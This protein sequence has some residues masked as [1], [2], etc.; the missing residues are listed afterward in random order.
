MFIVSENPVY[1][2]IHKRKRGNKSSSYQEM[3]LHPEKQNVSL[4]SQNETPAVLGC[5]SGSCHR[6]VK[7]SPVSVHRQNQEEVLQALY[8]SLS[9]KIRP[10]KLK[11]GDTVR[12][13]Q[14][15]KR[16]SKGYLPQ[17]TEERFRVKVVR[18]TAPVIYTVTDR[19]GNDVRGSFYGHY[20]I[21][22]IFA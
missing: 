11:D 4:F 20:K 2:F 6:S 1:C 8:G 16:F 22:T 3:T 9:A 21:E 14:A 19:F 15:R 7:A 12:L 10:P 18:K 5:T 13:S 17:R